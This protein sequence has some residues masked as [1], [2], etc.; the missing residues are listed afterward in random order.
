MGR[1]DLN[2]KAA[3][4]PEGSS[5]ELLGSLGPKEWEEEA[6]LG[7]QKEGQIENS[8]SDFHLE[9][10]SQPR[11]P[12]R[13]QENKYFS[14]FNFLLGHPIGWTYLVARGC[15]CPVDTVHQPPR[16]ES[17]VE[18]SGGWLLGA[19]G[20]RQLSTKVKTVAIA[21]RKSF[22]QKDR[23]WDTIWVP[24]SC[25]TIWHVQAQNGKGEEIGRKREEY[26]RNKVMWCVAVL[27]TVSQWL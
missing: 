26:I 17:K 1:V 5:V 20:K 13:H 12:H 8:S 24:S 15:G 16:A 3:P 21:F 18:K 25:N 7:N 14:P 27:A 9:G 6:G 23:A 22:L 11:W 10:H 19:R 2:H 4:Y